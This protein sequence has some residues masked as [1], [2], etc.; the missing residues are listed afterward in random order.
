MTA[1]KIYT[2]QNFLNAQ[3]RSKVFPLLFDLCYLK[4]TELRA[5][6]EL[7]DDIK[8]SDILI[9]PIDINSFKRHSIEYNNFFEA[10]VNENKPLWY[11]LA[12]DSD[13]VS[14]IQLG[15][16]FR[17]GGF[18]SK[19]SNNII[20]IP[21]F[22]NDPYDENPVIKFSVLKKFEKPTIGFVGH[23][24]NS[25][26]VLRKGMVRLVLYSIKEGGFSFKS[27][28]NRFFY[29]SQRAKYLKRLQR[30]HRF[31]TQF[32]FRKNYRA[33]LSVN[34]ELRKITTDEFFLNIRDNMFTF[35][36][37]GA[38]NFSVRFFQVLAMGRIPILFNTDCPLPLCDI[39]DWKE[40]VLILE[41]EMDIGLQITNFFD[42]HSEDELKNIQT[43]NRQ[44]WI[45]HLERV[46]YFIKINKKFNYL[47]K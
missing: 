7:T 2:N 29:V 20:T 9:V 44:L 30:D 40:H 45:T 28:K 25:L 3:N 32:I 16:E 24:D 23:A 39:I 26:K 47:L 27:V 14:K 22:I 38:G 33:G 19:L 15:Y 42:N 4:N 11:Y 12:G 18:Q 31:L 6:Y 10:S 34:S 41:N 17:L 46:N 37:R 1:L 36:M 21:A 43:K 8:D 13:Q 35:C 5:Y